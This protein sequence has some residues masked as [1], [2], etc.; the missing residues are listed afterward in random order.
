MVEW[1]GDSAAQVAKLRDRWMR[2]IENLNPGVT[3][4]EDMLRDILLRKMGVSQAPFFRNDLAHYR[5]EKKDHTNQLFL[6]SMDRFIDD[7]HPGAQPRSSGG[8]IRQRE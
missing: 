3:F 4:Q 7:F 1:Q 2:V 8:R 6:D 5:R